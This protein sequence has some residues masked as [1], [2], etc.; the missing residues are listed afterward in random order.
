MRKAGVPN[1]ALLEGLYN[2]APSNKEGF[3]SKRQCE[4]CGD[5]LAGQRYECT[6]TLGKEHTNDRVKLE[7]CEDCF[8]YLFS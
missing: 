3:F 7:V 4:S 6:V 5:C 2:F 8:L 1:D